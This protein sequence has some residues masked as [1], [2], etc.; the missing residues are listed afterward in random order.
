MRRK[1]TSVLIVLG[2]VAAGL[3]S[4]TACGSGSDNEA[5]TLHILTSAKKMDLDPAKSQSLAITALS[6]VAR[7]LTTWEI[8]QDGSD[9]K[10]VPDLATDTGTPSNGGKTW[11]YT[12][13]DGLKFENGDP[14]TSKDVKWGVERTFATALSGGLTF[15]KSVLVGGDEYEG[16]FSG[17][18]LDSIETPDDKTIIFQLKRSFGDWP[19]VVSTNPFAPVPHGETN[20][21]SYGEHPAAT[22]PYKVESYEAGDKLVLVRNDNWDK[23]SDPNRAGEAQKSVVEL[24]QNQDTAT[25]R[26]I[27]DTGKDQR[28]FST[29][30]VSPSKLPQI[31]NKPD[32][33]KRLVTSQ[34]G[35]LAF[36]A[37]N[38]ES[39]ALNNVEVRKALQYAVDK[40]AYRISRGGEIAGDF[41][42]T[43]ITPGIPG[44]DEYDL[45]EADSSGDVDKAKEILKQ[46]GV[47][48]TSLTLRL[49]ADSSTQG[50]S[51]AQAIQ[52][53]I[54]RTGIKV[55]IVSIDEEEYYDKLT[56]NDASTY[57]IALASWQPDYPSANG[58]I[59]PLFATSS[60]GGGNYNTARFS[61]PEVDKAIYEA[62]GEINPVK[63]GQLWAALDKKILEQ[64]PVVPLIYT[65]NTWL[66]GS[67]IKGFYIGAFPAYPNYLKVSVEE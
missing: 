6:L 4:L 2:F 45:Y 17:K 67:K 20:T 51:S 12:L 43:L 31:Q 18:E 57:D 41:A 3:T 63:A 25:D 65:K 64:A 16:P 29:S 48:P 26:L 23:A 1:I 59:E 66:I 36:L 58:N 37:L 8:P 44:R 38:T 24:N 47:E 35:A 11:K 56:G 49:L 22:G 55:N 9:P 62:Q 52:Q 27:A 50:Q 40:N 46:A 42:S 13:K 34:D 60:I 61:D 21:T 14:I 32:A 28:A 30:F 7:R 39:S 53:G 10:V 54:E 5:S 19:W 33:A 15:H